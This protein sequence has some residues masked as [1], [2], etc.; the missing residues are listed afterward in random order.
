MDY[1]VDDLYHKQPYQSDQDEMEELE[2]DE[3]MEEEM[4]NEKMEEEDYEESS[5]ADYIEWQWLKTFESEET[6]EGVPIAKMVAQR[7]D[8]EPIRANFYAQM[9]EPTHD[10]CELAFDLFDRWGC[11]KDDF[12]RHPIKK[13]TG[14]WGKELNEGVI[15][16]FEYISVDR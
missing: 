1:A 13:G 4:D 2:D 15:L 6:R 9:E 3:E 11:V 10:T 14:V 8:R 16:L 12:L 7:I 5:I